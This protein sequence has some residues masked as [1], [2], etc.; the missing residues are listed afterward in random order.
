METCAS[1]KAGSAIRRQ[2]RLFV[3]NHGTTLVTVVDNRVAKPKAM[4][5]QP[6]GGQLARPARSDRTYAEKCST[7]DGSAR[8]RRCPRNI[9]A[10]SSS[11]QWCNYL[12]ELTKSDDCRRHPDAIKSGPSSQYS[13]NNPL[14]SLAAHV[15]IALF[16]TERMHEGDVP[17]TARHRFA[18]AERQHMA[19]AKVQ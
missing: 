14:R 7:D 11:H 2:Q 10:Q 6:D 12:S 8:C 4:R 16:A 13:G 19:D 17:V 5:R 3:V 1:E 18:A 9:H 15:R